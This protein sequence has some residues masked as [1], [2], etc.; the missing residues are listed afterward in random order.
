[1]THHCNSG[2]NPAKVAFNKLSSSSLSSSYRQSFE[3]QAD[4]IIVVFNPTPDKFRP[5]FFSSVQIYDFTIYCK[6]ALK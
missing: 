1:M 3:H 2:E 5:E 4:V 6:S